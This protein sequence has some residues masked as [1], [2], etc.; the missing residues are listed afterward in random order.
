MKKQINPTIKAHLIR[1]AFY[2][3][4]LV[5]VCA[6]W[7]NWDRNDNRMCLCASDSTDGGGLGACGVRRRGRDPRLRSG[8]RI[9]RRRGGQYAAVSDR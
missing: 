5:A 7:S 9:A 6:I 8:R 1:G 3:L 2:L 4:V